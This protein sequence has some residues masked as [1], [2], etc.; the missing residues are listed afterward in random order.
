MASR[1][2]SKASRHQ[3]NTDPKN[4][5]E[6]SGRNES[7][8]EKISKK[9]GNSIISKHPSPKWSTPTATTNCRDNS[10]TTGSTN[11]V[12][13]SETPEAVGAVVCNTEISASTKKSINKAKK[14]T[15]SKETKPST[16]LVLLANQQNSQQ[17]ASLTKKIAKCLQYLD[18]NESEWSNGTHPG[19]PA[20]HRDKHCPAPANDTEYHSDSID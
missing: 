9:A 7:S 3:S 12:D 8:S 11:S 13:S 14:I 17:K 16:C 2:L 15:K 10:S 19:N 18:Y 20:P 1:K 4:S 6:L 5:E